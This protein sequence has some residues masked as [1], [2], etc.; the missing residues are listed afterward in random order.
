MKT[1]IFFR[2]YIFAS[3][4]RNLDIMYLILSDVPSQD[5]DDLVDGVEASQEQQYDTNHY[6]GGE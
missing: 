1:V 4:K 6:F 3:M 5:A 2:A